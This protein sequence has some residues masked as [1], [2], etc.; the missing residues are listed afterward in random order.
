MVS[1]KHERMNA[2]SSKPFK[3]YFLGNRTALSL[4]PLL[5]VVFLATGFPNSA[6]SADDQCDALFSDSLSET[7]SRRKDLV[8]HYAKGAKTFADVQHFAKNAAALPYAEKQTLL[9]DIGAV[10]REV[11]KK[12]PSP[13]AAWHIGG[14][15]LLD[16]A[17]TIIARTDLFFKTENDQ[18]TSGAV[19]YR[20]FLR[21]QQELFASNYTA[22]E[23]F[24]VT[25]VLQKNLQALQPAG[26]I[27]PVYK[28]LLAGSF[29][30][31]KA[32]L[33]KSDLDMT[34]SAPQLMSEMLSWEKQVNESLQAALGGA[35]VRMVLEAHSQ[36][37]SFYGKI[38]PVVIEV[39]RDSVQLL[40]FEPAKLQQRSSE[41]Q[42]GAMAIY[43]L[44]LPFRDHP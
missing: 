34:L 27:G 8:Q 24:L 29:I 10:Y 6:F 13:T 12:N 22:D 23:V 37:A 18:G 38:N 42:A 35:A 31:G 14:R 5:T 21:Q 36:P 11:P 4:V 43:P 44:M 2:I 20:K 39:T 17:Q 30:N 7:T 16:Y 9:L 15:R 19:A 1:A 28:L 32:N 33:N 25:Q 26:H 40:V 41:L 3:T